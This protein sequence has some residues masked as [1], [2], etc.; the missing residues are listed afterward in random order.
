M[1]AAIGVW[2]LVLGGWVLPGVYEPV[3]QP[4]SPAYRPSSAESGLQP[5][6]S[7]RGPVAEGQQRGGYGQGPQQGMRSGDLDQDILTLP[8]APTHPSAGSD[9]LPFGSPTVNVPTP[10]A[11]SQPQPAAGETPRSYRGS[12]GFGATPTTGRRPVGARTGPTR[13]A[14]IQS[15]FA[16]QSLNRRGLGQAGGVGS[17][18]GSNKPFA[19]YR[20]AP[21]ISPYMNLFRTDNAYGTID[22]YS[23]LVRP[24]ISQR[25]MNTRVG[26]AIRGLQST[27]RALDFQTRGVQGA[28]GQPRYMN[29]GGYYPGLSGR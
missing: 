12:V 26:G 14:N 18:F 24:R 7:T 9:V 8:F 1:N 4:D 3:A 13:Q 6:G 15:P 2:T 20:Q 5:G 23:T 25:S 28:S 21:A 16:P 29:Y 22:N 17:S 19:D 10:G 11:H 27:T